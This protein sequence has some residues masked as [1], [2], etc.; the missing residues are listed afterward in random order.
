MVQVNDDNNQFQNSIQNIL[1]GSSIGAEAKRLYDLMTESERLSLLDGDMDFWEGMRDLQVNGY[2]YVPYS[3]GKV[4]RIGLPGLQFTDGPRGVVIGKSTAFPVSMAR[5]ASWD[6]QLEK[7]VGQVI[8]VE[9]RAQGANFFAG[10]CINLPRHPAWGRSQETYGEDPVLLGEMGAALT[11][12]AS[13]NVM[14]CVKHFAL[15]SMENAR[16]SVNV[17]A[18]EPALHEVYLPHFKRVIDEHADAVMS[19]YNSVNGEW[20]GQNRSL[21]TETLRDFWN[22]EGIVVSDFIFG[23]RDAQKS[24]TAG[25]DVEMPF[26]QQRKK[27]FEDLQ[28]QGESADWQVIARAAIR[29]LSVQLRFYARIHGSK[30]PEVSEVFS[31]SHRDLARLVATSSAVLLKNETIDLEP[32][33]PLD[34]DRIKK[35]ALIGRLAALKNTGDHGSSEVRTP[36][37]I[38]AVEGITAK[39]SNSQVD[40]CV[41]DDPAASAEIAAK[42]DVAIVVVGFTSED[43]GEF[44][45]PTISSRKDLQELF[46]PTPAGL[47]PSSAAAPPGPV[48]PE[49]GHGGD[50]KR[51]TL[52]PVDEEIIMAVSAVNPRTIVAIVAGGTVMVENWI[53]EPAAVLMSWY[54]GS[55]GGSALAEV[56]AGDAEPAGRLPFAI[57]RSEEHLPFFDVDATNITYDLWHGQR[58]LDHDGHAAR[59]P[60]GFGLGYGKV[61]NLSLDIKERSEESCLVVAKVQNVSE[62]ATKHSVQI[63]GLASEAGITV[64]KLLAFQPVFLKPFEQAEVEVKVPLQPLRTWQQESTQFGLVPENVTLELSSY[65]GDPNSVSS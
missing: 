41:E 52:R 4:D 14:T 54:A 60:F 45:D 53:A 50:R 51:L 63:Y 18:D 29:I 17:N 38:S 15:N 55:E 37:V 59:F 24:L 11:S 39:F 56:L 27:Y 13:E 46:P 25:L 5:G 32:A 43:E 36:E 9:S 49:F 35:I 42:A 34:R 22:F 2:N 21:L 10:I 65:S 20:C 26:G 58:K 47:D 28:K 33:L 57:P 6:P 31:K 12:G 1:G 64:R 30:V 8:G 44:L 62:L 23:L 3:H 40:L 16:F 7:R 61:A 48:N 19:A